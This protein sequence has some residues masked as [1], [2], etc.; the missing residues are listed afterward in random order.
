L[1]Y[2]DPSNAGLLE[3][4]THYAFKPEVK[5]YS[6][7]QTFSSDKN[8]KLGKE[9]KPGETLIEE[10]TTKG[11]DLRSASYKGNYRD[12]GIC[13]GPSGQY[14]VKLV[15]FFS[16]VIM[17]KETKSFRSKAMNVL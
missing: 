14:M 4:S 10:W 9:L 15:A 1:Q 6:M 11:N 2:L 8:I 17:R 3:V 5:E 13:F 12:V 16:P 7:R